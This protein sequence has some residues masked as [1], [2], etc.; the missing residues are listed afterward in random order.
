MTATTQRQDVAVRGL[1]ATGVLTASQAEAVLAALRDTEASADGPRGWWV[2][3]L[4]YVGG[5]LLLA[6]A[7]TLVGL[8]WE[9]LSRVGK[10][11]LLGA[12]TFVLLCAAAVVGGGRTSGRLRA[13]ALAAVRRRVVGVLCGLA[14]AAAALAVGVAVDNDPKVAAPVAGILV[15][16][17]GY[18]WV[19][20]AFGLLVAAGFSVYLAATVLDGLSGTTWAVASAV[21]FVALGAGWVGLALS[22]LVV[23]RALGLACG[24]V[25]ALVGGQ[26]PVGSDIAG[27]GYAVTLAVAVGCLVLY[28]RERRF[29]LLAAGVIGVTIAVPEAVW[30]V[31]DGAGG[32]AAVLLVAGATLLAT[33]GVGLRARWRDRQA[34]STPGLSYRRA[35]AGRP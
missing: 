5:G 9:D 32:A 10:V 7:G 1:V 6:G 15:A 11:V 33:S 35:R 20:T 8:S 31:T 27:W 13:D 14:A 19:R 24:A 3:V 17:V 28:R 29:V 12:V 22:G 2:E 18:A 4:G 23:P 25:I 26:L 16:A 34:A 30:D 21:T